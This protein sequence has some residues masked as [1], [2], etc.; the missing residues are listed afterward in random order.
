M[1][2]QG[3]AMAL[4]SMV[5]YLVDEASEIEEGPESIA[6]A[7]Q[8]VLERGVF[9]GCDTQYVLLLGV[10][11]GCQLLRHRLSKTLHG[12][13]VLLKMMSHVFV[14][15]QTFEDSDVLPIIDFFESI[16]RSYS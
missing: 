1:V 7:L 2:T 10:K 11:I 4:L 8:I 3:T 15:E 14:V 5:G 12:L 16:F 9:S 6:F 13:I